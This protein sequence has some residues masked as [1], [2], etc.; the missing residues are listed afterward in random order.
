[1]TY[2]SIPEKI[3]R[4]IPLPQYENCT[5]SDYIQ[6]AQVTREWFD[7]HV[8]RC[9]PL[10]I[11]N[12]YGFILY[13]PFDFS[14]MWNGGQGPEDVQVWIDE[15]NIPVERR[16]I[17]NPKASFGRGIMTIYPG[18][19]LKT[20]P[21]IN[22]LVKNPPNFFMDNTT[23][24]EGVVEADNLNTTF[25]YNIRI[26][27]PHERIYIKQGDPIGCF[28]PYP[29]F[30]FDDFKLEISTD[31]DELDYYARKQSLFGAVRNNYTDTNTYRKGKDFDGC[32]FHNHQV[33]VNKPQKQGE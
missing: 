11:A 8:Y 31:S 10:A 14:F 29:R 23:W 13:A 1:M 12:Q 27:R 25:S 28:I 3:V 2:S 16:G 33:A 26:H 30:F 18:F 20:G 21:D 4:L 7:P 6:R 9:L 32:P 5:F 15:P 24:L 17:I 19:I 22:L